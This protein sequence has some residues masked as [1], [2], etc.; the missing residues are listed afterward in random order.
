MAV[1]VLLLPHRKPQLPLF[2]LSTTTTSLRLW[3]GRKSCF[4]QGAASAC[5]LNSGRHLQ[6][7][8]Y[9]IAW[10]LQS[11]PKKLLTPEYSA[12]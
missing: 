7:E 1:A 6:K 3:G 10:L 11:R 9:N 5:A 4:A 8:S 2:F 12:S